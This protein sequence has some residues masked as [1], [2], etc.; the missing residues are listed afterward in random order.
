M[1]YGWN[2]DV[3]TLI[4]IGKWLFFFSTTNVR[5]SWV[6]TQ[7]QF[8]PSIEKGYTTHLINPVVRHAKSLVHRKPFVQH[9]RI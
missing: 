4:C 5:T 1:P 7:H 6:A 9:M 2:V 8:E 3:V